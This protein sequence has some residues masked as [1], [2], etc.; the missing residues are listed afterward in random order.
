MPK[1]PPQGMYTVSYIHHRSFEQIDWLKTSNHPECSHRV[2]LTRTVVSPAFWQT[3]RQNTSTDF[4]YAEVFVLC[5]RMYVTVFSMP[6]SRCRLSH[7]DVLQSYS[8]HWSSCKR[9]SIARRDW[10]LTCQKAKGRCK[11]ITHELRLNA[12]T[13]CS[14]N[15]ERAASILVAF[16]MKLIKCCVCHTITCLNTCDIWQLLS[17]TSLTLRNNNHWL[18]D[19]LPALA[20]MSG[21]KA[22]SAVIK[23]EE[24]S[25]H[26][27]WQQLSMESS[28]ASVTTTITTNDIG[29]SQ[30]P[31]QP[32]KVRLSTAGTQT[33]QRTK[34]V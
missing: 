9:T 31:K 29:S 11:V 8:A 2:V 14:W 28:S 20:V 34:I 13:T 21:L 15:L 3:C 19:I 30:N 17:R 24:V 26:T 6:L 18:W 12:K 5:S 1:T 33:Q 32:S 16:A 22:L 25:L 10:S 23:H 4:S 7:V 27:L